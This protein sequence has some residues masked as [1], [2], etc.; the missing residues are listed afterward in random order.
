MQNNKPFRQYFVIA[1]FGAGLA[2]IATNTVE[3]N[4]FWV[5]LGISIKT[6]YGFILVPLASHI[7][8]FHNG[9]VLY[10]IGFIVQGFPCFLVF[11]LF[12]FLVH[13][14]LPL[15]YMFF[16]YHSIYYFF[17]IFFIAYFPLYFILSLDI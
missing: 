17:Y 1:M 6:F 2:P 3:L 7:I 14:F 9:Y 11:V 15:F 8:R 5:I 10:N 13:S 4:I 12:F 16:C